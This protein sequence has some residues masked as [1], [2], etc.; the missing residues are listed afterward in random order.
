[1][2]AHVDHEVLGPD[3]DDS[4]IVTEPDSHHFDLMHQSVIEKNL[5]ELVNGIRAAG[6][7]SVP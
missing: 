5:A 1:M 6:T 3:F 2:L 7:R 4:E